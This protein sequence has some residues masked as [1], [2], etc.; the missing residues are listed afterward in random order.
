MNL[1][2][3]VS[4]GSQSGDTTVVQKGLP[5]S[6]SNTKS[7]SFDGVNDKASF[8]NNQV[9]P[10]L[11]GAGDFSISWWSKAPS[12][13]PP[14]NGYKSTLF[15]S[16]YFAGNFRTFVIGAIG[17][18][19]NSSHA[20]KFYSQVANGS[21]NYLTV[22]SSNAI[23]SELTNNDW[24][25]F[26]FTSSAGASSRTH[27]LYV[28]NTAITLTSVSSAVDFSDFG[29]VA[30]DFGDIALGA[31]TFNAGSDSYE[32]IETDELVVTNNVLSSSDVSDIYNSGVPKDESKRSGLIGYWRF[33]DNG[34]DSSSN[35]N[36][37]TITGATFTDDVPS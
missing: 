4:I 8:A 14:G 24:N 30:A 9:L 15:Y 20:G 3:G 36:A 6:F 35:S 22:T 18:S 11:I 26:V 34:D 28:N 31:T 13:S 33:E 23:T 21:T 32:N 17:D 2:L 5:P 37:L 29:G 12:F 27:T 1:G 16:L 19:G 7:I 25:H 10:E